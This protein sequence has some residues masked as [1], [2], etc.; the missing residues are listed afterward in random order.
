MVKLNVDAAFDNPNC[1]TGVGGVFRDANGTFLRGFRHSLPRAASIRHAKLHAL[2]KGLEY[3]LSDHLVLLIVETD[4]Q[5]LVY[6]VTGHSLDHS[7]LGF[8]IS[9]LKQLLQQ[10]DSAILFHVKRESNMSYF[11]LKS[12]APCLKSSA[13]LTLF[14]PCLTS[15]AP[16]MAAACP[17]PQQKKT[18]RLPPPKRGKIKAR[19]LGNLVKA[20]VSIV[21]H[22]DQGKKMASEA[23]GGSAAPTP[24]PSG[25]NSYGSPNVV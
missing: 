16:T 8:F 12:S 20:V 15:H 1:L 19:I 9:D 10:V 5:E 13:S 22:G 3:A 4:C 18:T 2:I 24:P 25:Y 21:K 7:D 23:G 17:T 14:T 11:S 6:A